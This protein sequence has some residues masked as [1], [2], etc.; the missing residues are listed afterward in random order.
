[1]ENEYGRHNVR[2]PNI[3]LKSGNCGPSEWRP[4][5]IAAP[6]N[7]GRWEWRPLGMAAPNP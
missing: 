3:M 1:M 4:L 6:E 7:G 5:G 2:L